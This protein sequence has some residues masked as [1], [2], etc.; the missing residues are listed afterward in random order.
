MFTLTASEKQNKFFA[1]NL[2]IEFGAI[3]MG[4]KGSVIVSSHEESSVPVSIE[5]KKMNR[6][7][8]TKISMI[9]HNHPGNSGPSGFHI[10]SK[11]GDK[12]RISSP[13]PG[14]YTK[15]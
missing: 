14:K 8:D 6:D 13:L 7:W 1:D 12:Y 15:C 11:E 5:A 10:N 4:K 2:G 3:M 9:I